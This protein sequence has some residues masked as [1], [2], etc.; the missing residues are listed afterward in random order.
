MIT[1]KHGTPWTPREEHV[2]WT[3]A[4]TATRQDVADILGR[5]LGAIYAKSKVLKV[6]FAKRR[7]HL[8]YWQPHEDAMLRQF[9]LGGDILRTA[10]HRI[11]RTYEGALRRARRLKIKFTFN[12]GKSTWTTEEVDTAKEM[13]PLFTGTEIAHK[14]GRGLTRE[15]VIGMMRRQK[16]PAKQRHKPNPPTAVRKRMQSIG[17]PRPALRPL[18]RKST[19]EF[20]LGN[21]RSGMKAPKELPVYVDVARVKHADLQWHH[22]RWPVGDPQTSHSREF[23][24]GSK[25]VTGLPYCEQHNRRAYREIS[26]APIQSFANDVGGGKSVKSA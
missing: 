12:R 7:T 17:T 15:A 8:K 1:Q 16:M 5:T 4:E 18:P 13:W 3:L 22:C 20:A 14:L 25:R 6:R 19:K 2:L 11:G 24:C 10:A 23:F 21:W 26:R 9:A